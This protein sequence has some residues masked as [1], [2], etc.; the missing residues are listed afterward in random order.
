MKICYNYMVCKANHNEFTIPLTETF[1]KD[2]IDSGD[3]Y[4]LLG[5]FENDLDNIKIHKILDKD[6]YRNC[7]DKLLRSF[8]FHYDNDTKFDWF[9]IGDD[10]TYTNVKNLNTFIQ[11]LETFHFKKDSLYV[12]C[13]AEKRNDFE[14]SIYGGSG[15]LINRKTFLTICKW[16]IKTNYCINSIGHGDHALCQ[17]I[18]QYNSIS[19]PEKRIKFLS[20]HNF[21]PC[22]TDAKHEPWG[23]YTTYHLKSYFHEKAP[24]IRE[25]H[26]FVK[27]NEIE[28]SYRYE[29]FYLPTYKGENI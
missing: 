9:F 29:E 18:I 19:E 2:I 3:E 15:I 22:Y 12:V 14:G 28:F 4:F 24:T 1:G 21:M 5:G 7:K 16:L 23:Y 20:A 17:N 10:D 11:S 26:N 6:D 13:R 8:E 25:F 27:S